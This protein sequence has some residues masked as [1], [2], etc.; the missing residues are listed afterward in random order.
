MYVIWKPFFLLNKLTNPGGIMSN[1]LL[2]LIISISY[3]SKPY[4]VRWGVLDDL[5]AEVGALD[6]AEILLIALPVA[7]VLVEDVGRSS[8]NLGVDDGGPQSLGFHLREK[9]QFESAKSPINENN[10]AW[11]ILFQVFRIA[12]GE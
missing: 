12:E 7:G 1:H 5:G 2:L 9:H 4:L 10:N 8:L 3:C 6:G 11:A